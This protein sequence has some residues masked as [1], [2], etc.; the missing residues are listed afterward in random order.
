MNT[1]DPKYIALQFNEY[2]NAR[3]TKG[4]AR[5]MTKNH[6]FIDSADDIHPGKEYMVSGW[7][8]FFKSYPDYKNTFNRI[9]SRENFVVIIGFASCSNEKLLDGP[10]LWSAKIEDD[11]VAEWRVYHDTPENR[12]KLSF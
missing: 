9:E 8:K 3:D 11:L 5:L 7:K 10:F 6:T 12:K 2:I 4:L 1:K